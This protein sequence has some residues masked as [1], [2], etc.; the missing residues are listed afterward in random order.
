MSGEGL[1]VAPSVPDET[2]T[3]QPLTLSQTRRPG[4]VR[5]HLISQAVRDGWMVVAVNFNA[6]I[7]L[8]L[9]PLTGGYGAIEVLILLAVQTMACGLVALIL[10]IL[11][12]RRKGPSVAASDT[13]RATAWLSFGEVMLMLAWGAPAAL[14]LP[15]GDFERDML[16]IMTLT[17]I[18]VISAAL[19]SRLPAALI[20]G[21][22]A[23]FAP[24]AIS[25][26]YVQQDQWVL[27]T[28]LTVFAA[29]TT[30]AV[31]YA[32]YV[33]H[34]AQA[35]QA[36]KLREARDAL[37]DA[38]GET[39]RQR[40]AA[41]RETEMR[42]RFMRAVT[43][44]LRQPV[45]ALGHYLDDLSRREPVSEDALHPLRSCVISANTV[46]D[47]VAQLALVTEGLPP[48]ELKP[49]ALGPL[50][51]RLSLETQALAAHH[52]LKLVAA[53]STLWVMADPDRLERSVRN[54][55]HNAIQY[56]DEGGILVG[57]RPR[58]ERVA[59]E[60]W[61]SGRG[62]AA[63]DRDAIFEAFQQGPAPP[64]RALGSIGLGLGI[65]R[66]FAH[67]MKGD[68]GL[69]SAPGQG[70]RFTLWL[71]RAAPEAL[72]APARTSLAGARVMIVDDDAAFAARA[73]EAIEAEGASVRLV[74]DIAEM[75]ALDQAAVEA[76]DLLLLDID[77]G[78]GLT[79]FELRRSFGEAVPRTLMVTAAASDEVRRIAR[80]GGLRLVEKRSVRALVIVLKGLLRDG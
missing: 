20:F 68:V 77:L 37:R 49:C 21:R 43:H 72:E 54:L 31:G 44:D 29:A 64:S 35:T 13:I 3:R 69:E 61:D 47:S 32:T 19:T 74:T 23:L 30:L 26:A 15:S 14:L 34:L 80:E 5:R 18:G 22:I 57:A 1:L 71:D 73:A 50:I 9:V 46:I 48:A 38:L 62:I 40:E 65:V 59:V 79:G 41:L 7:F 2:E 51:A 10:L 12:L 67:S 39:E 70:S 76:V 28:A 52:G 11:A 16:F 33:Q 75:R 6:A 36:V 27:L 55:I 78:Q 58:G 45:G 25:L 42:E 24:P 4:S 17:V 66:E 63:E 56:T 8:G 53:K 60:V